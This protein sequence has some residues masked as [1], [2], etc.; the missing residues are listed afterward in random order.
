VPRNS[1]QAR[2]RVVRQ[3]C[4]INHFACA[5]VDHVERPPFRS[6]RANGLLAYLRVGV[7][8]RDGGASLAYR[9]KPATA[10]PYLHDML[11]RIDH[12]PAFWPARGSSTAAAGEQI[13]RA[14]VLNLPQ[15]LRQVSC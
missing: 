14:H 7:V 10:Q 5:V 2:L 3:W 1:V 15:A 4:D 6:C 8:A 9:R 13:S 12:V 11:K